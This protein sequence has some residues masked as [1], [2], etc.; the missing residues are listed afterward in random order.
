MRDHNVFGINER[1]GDCFEG[2]MPTLIHMTNLDEN[3]S[4]LQT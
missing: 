4:V 2:R 1:E 3:D